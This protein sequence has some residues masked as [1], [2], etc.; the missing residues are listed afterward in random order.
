[1]WA[2]HVPTIAPLTT[3]MPKVEARGVMRAPR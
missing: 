1:M 2:I 3:K